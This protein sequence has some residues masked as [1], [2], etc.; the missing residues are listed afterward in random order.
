M[1][2]LEEFIEELTDKYIEDMRS[3]YPFDLSWE[4]IL[5]ACYRTGV[6]DGIKNYGLWES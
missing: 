2:N 6:L 3:R 5:R 1:K 4:Q